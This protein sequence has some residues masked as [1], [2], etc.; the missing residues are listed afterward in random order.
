MTSR[1]SFPVDPAPSTRP[2]PCSGGVLGRSAARGGRRA[3][4][5]GR[6]TRPAPGHRDGP[7][8]GP[9]HI[10]GEF[11][12]IDILATLYGAGAEHVARRPLDD[13][14]RDRF[15]LSKGHAAGALYTTLAA[16]GFLPPDELSTFMQAAVAAQRA[17]GPHQGAGG[18]GQHRSARSRAADRRRA[19]LRGQARRLR[20]GAPSC[21][22]RRGAAGGLE[23]GGADD[24]RQPRARAPVRRSSTATGCSR[25]PRVEETNDLEPLAEKLAAFGLEVVDVDGHDH[26]ALLDVLS[27]VPFRAGQADRRDRPHPQGPP[28][29]V[30]VQ[31]RRLAPQGPHDRTV[32]QALAELERPHDHRHTAVAA[33]SHDCRD[34]WVATLVD[35]A[36]TDR[37][38]VAVVNDSVGSSKLGPSRTVPGP[39]DE[40]RDRRAGHGRRRRGLANGGKIPFVSAAACFLTARAMEQIKADVAYSHTI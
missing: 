32:A 14:E 7:R 28:D 25:A 1:T 40:R 5:R 15:I 26:G 13:P 3:P 6:P 8:A 29:L 17:P 27:A 34:A 35:L 20:R 38:I 36:E 24:R 2:C 4:R 19:R 37:R 12:V 31:Q 22:R 11:S 33:S 16:S 10:G 18:R 21:R 39:A 30:H 9:G 23:L